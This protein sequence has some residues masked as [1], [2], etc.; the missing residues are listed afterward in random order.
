M[1]RQTWEP[2]GPEGKGGVRPIGG[3]PDDI[4]VAIDVGGIVHVDPRDTEQ[5]RVRCPDC[6]VSVMV[7]DWTIHRSQYHHDAK[8]LSEVGEQ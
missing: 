2:I 4:M 3:I 6:W 1:T 8:L 5:R 7:R